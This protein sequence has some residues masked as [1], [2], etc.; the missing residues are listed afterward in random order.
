M[1]N[2]IMKVFSVIILLGIVG[3]LIM[4]TYGVITEQY[5]IAYVSFVVVGLVPVA[6]S[7]IRAVFDPYK[8]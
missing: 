8:D 4:G 7:V 6:I 5:G 1:E 3:L 2:K